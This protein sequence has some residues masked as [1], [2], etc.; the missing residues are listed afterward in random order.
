[1]EANFFK[2][3]KISLM[4]GLAAEDL[5]EYDKKVPLVLG[6]FADSF[7]LEKTCIQAE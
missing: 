6:L 3:Y 4:S 2:L 7:E 1:M 5:I